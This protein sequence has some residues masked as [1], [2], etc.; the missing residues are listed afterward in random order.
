[1]GLLQCCCTVL[2]TDVL[3]FCLTMQAI[4]AAVRQHNDP[5]I[6]EERVSQQQD[7]GTTAHASGNP[8]NK[9]LSLALRW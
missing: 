4:M 5:P 8:F 2:S 3:L 7:L 1:M 6:P 9:Q